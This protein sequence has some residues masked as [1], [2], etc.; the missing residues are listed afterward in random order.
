MYFREVFSPKTQIPYDSPF[1]HRIVTFR[2]CLYKIFDVQLALRCLPMET[3]KGGQGR[4]P[5]WYHLSGG[6][7]SD[8]DSGE[9][10]PVTPLSLSRAMHAVAVCCKMLGNPCKWHYVKVGD[11]REGP[12]RQK[13]TRT[14]PKT[15]YWVSAEITLS[16]TILSPGGKVNTRKWNGINT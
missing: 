10:S 13:W 12:H 3:M 14:R 5:L 4:S 1:F 16:D 7:W 2:E 15:G 11:S 8:P 6:E 9:A